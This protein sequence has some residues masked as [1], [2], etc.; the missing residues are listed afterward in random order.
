L[1]WIGKE[2]LAFLLEVFVVVGDVRKVDV[3]RIA[4]KPLHE[5]Y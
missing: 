5:E 4:L 2:W 3:E 1:I